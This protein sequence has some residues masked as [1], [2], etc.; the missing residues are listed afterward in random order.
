[1]PSLQVLPIRKSQRKH[2]RDIVGTVGSLDIKQLIVPTRKATKI[3]V[4]KSQKR[5][6]EKHSTKGD[7]KGKG[8]R[9]MSKV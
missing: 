1:M 6:Q 8:H 2:Y 4:R 3:L 5:A 7:S 9:D